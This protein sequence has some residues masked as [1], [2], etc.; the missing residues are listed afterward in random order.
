MKNA[1]RILMAAVL[2][3]GLAGCAAVLSRAGFSGEDL[4]TVAAAATKNAKAVP[5]RP[6]E[7]SGP[8]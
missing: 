2:L 7:P 4:A 3:A 1:A 8:R 6:A 5:N